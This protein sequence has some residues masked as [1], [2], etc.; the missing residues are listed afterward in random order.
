LKPR[1]LA[2][3]ASTITTIPQTLIKL[4][5]HRGNL[6]LHAPR[7][8]V[9]QHLKSGSHSALNNMHVLAGSL[10]GQCAFA[11]KGILGLIG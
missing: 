4:A 6:L 8:H 3:V 10:V 1:T 5:S 2:P 11:V 9:L 7:S